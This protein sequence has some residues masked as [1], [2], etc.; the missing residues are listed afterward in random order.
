[1]FHET[2]DELDYTPFKTLFQRKTK[3]MG[4]MFN[5]KGI[6]KILETHNIE[7]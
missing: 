3:C 5:L 6:R 1:M 7:Q 2:K 4:R